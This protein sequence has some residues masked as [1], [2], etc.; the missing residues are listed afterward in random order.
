MAPEINDNS[1]EGGD[2]G[3]PTQGSPSPDRDRPGVATETGE[4]QRQDDAVDQ[5]PEAPL[6]PEEAEAFEKREHANNPDGPAR[7][8]EA[9]LTPEEAGAFEKREHADMPDGSMSGE[10]ISPPSDTPSL[11]DRLADPRYLANRLMPDAARHSGP[12]G[13]D[14]VCTKDGEYVPRAE[15]DRGPSPVSRPYSWEAPGIDPSTG[16]KF[17]PRPDFVPPPDNLRQDPGIEG[18]PG[19]FDVEA[20]RDAINGAG[21]GGMAAMLGHEVGGNDPEHLP[22][23]AR[24]GRPIDGLAMAAAGMVAARTA[25]SDLKGGSERAP[26]DEL[27]P[28]R[29]AKASPEPPAPTQRDARTPQDEFDDFTKL[30]QEEGSTGV[31][32]GEPVTMQPH[33]GAREA[34]QLLDVTG[35]EAQSMHGL[36]RSVGK[37]MSGYDPNAALT[38]L[39]EKAMHTELDQPWKDA[40]QA[41]RHD[42]MTTASAQ[43]VYDAVAGSIDSSTELSPG[44]KDTLKLRL[45][46]EMFVEYGL[47]PGQQM[48]LPYPNIKPRP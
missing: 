14:Y 29:R 21:I 28:E 9:P 30:L 26:R 38:T 22:D 23:A 5:E 20:D 10:R 32:S 3:S 31:T 19:T 37:H 40:F 4:I 27:E 25:I 8:E 16:E 48:T 39:G 6:T 43:E 7:D 35:D 42:G 12:H 18:L 47:Q 46:D 1:Y 41:M 17:A 24:S 15:A 2:G 44:T 11:A 36:P 33:G 45:L 34:R 13:V